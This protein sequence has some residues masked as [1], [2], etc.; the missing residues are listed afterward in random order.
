MAIPPQPSKPKITDGIP[1]LA[2]KPTCVP[3]NLRDAGQTLENGRNDRDDPK[4]T[5]DCRAGTGP[6]L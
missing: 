3:A 6:Q 1:A 4:V 5:K 2:A